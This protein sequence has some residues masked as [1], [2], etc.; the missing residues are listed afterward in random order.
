MV[1]RPALHRTHPLDRREPALTELAYH[2]APD[3]LSVRAEPVIS[4][5]TL[6]VDPEGPGGERVARVLGPSLPTRPDTWVDT[7]DGQIIWLGPDE[8]LVTSSIAPPEVLE[9]TLLRVVAPHGGAAVDVSA[10]RT[11][12]RVRGSRARDL[13]ASGCSVDL[14]PSVMPAG[15]G[16]QTAIGQTGVLLLVLTAGVDFR[17]FVRP[18]FAGYLA[19]WLLDAAHEFRTGTETPAPS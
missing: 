16:A 11:G 7:A 12:L 10:Q 5:S 4:A 17:L 14:H 13:L 18:S 2:L 6:R 15:T 8:W 9:Q 1:E 19:D 3:E